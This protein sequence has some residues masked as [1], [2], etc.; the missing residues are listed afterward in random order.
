MEV[1]SRR[2]SDLFG[3]FHD[4][5]P[6]VRIAGPPNRKWSLTNELLWLLTRKSYVNPTVY[7]IRDVGI[8]PGK[9]ASAVMPLSGVLGREVVDHPVGVLPSL[10]EKIEA[11]FLPSSYLVLD[12]NSHEQLP[13]TVL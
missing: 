10:E 8:C 13:W 9:R 5:A 7:L 4:R 11:C 3:R 6:L 1:G 2:R 12:S